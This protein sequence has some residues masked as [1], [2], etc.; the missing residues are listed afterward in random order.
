MAI[1]TMLIGP[2]GC[3][4]STQATILHEEDTNSII[5]SSDAIRKELFGDESCQ[6]DNNRV[7]SIMTKRT[8]EY[9]SKGINVI[10]DS[11]NMSRNKRINILQQMPKDTESHAVIVA[12]SIEDI[13]TQDFKRY[14]TVGEDVIMSQLKAFQAPWFTEGFKHIRL[15]NNAKTSAVTLVSKMALCPH[16][17]PHHRDRSVWD[18]C[19]AMFFGCVN[20]YATKTTDF[21]RK[22]ILEDA[23][24]YHDCGKPYTKQFDEDGIAHYYGHA[25]VG[26]YLYLTV[27]SNRYYYQEGSDNRSL[28]VAVIIGEHM[29][30]HQKEFNV[31]K[32]EK[33]IGKDLVEL[34][35]E[36]KYYDETY[37]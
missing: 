14:R 6:L 37:A 1:F 29:R 33:H 8:K 30:M 27:I 15:V 24:K 22:S 11:T 12:T 31:S 36:L 28:E 25:G 19:K 20:D 32:L 35:K 23:C 9:L 4:K 13:F 34:C 5:L 17:N 18:H 3:G 7:F 2:A 26:A 16:N 21:V 10:W